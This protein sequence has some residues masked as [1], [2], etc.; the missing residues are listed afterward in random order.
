MQHDWLT[1][2]ADVAYFPPLVLLHPEP[3][4][5]R[6]VNPTLYSLGPT[7]STPK[8]LNPG[9]FSLNL[10]SYTPS[11]ESCS[12]HYKPHALQFYSRNLFGVLRQLPYCKGSVSNTLGFLSPKYC[13]L[14][15][16]GEPPPKALTFGCLDPRP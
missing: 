5:L 8:D 15:G 13:D 11:P 6:H 10:T 16:I 7:Q 3:Y 9:V 12:L 14:R 4:V 2:V 1:L